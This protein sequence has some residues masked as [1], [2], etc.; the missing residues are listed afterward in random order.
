MKIHLQATIEFLTNYGWAILI[1]A[2]V[3]IALVG[4]KVF[5]SSAFTSNTCLSSGNFYCNEA[6]INTSGTLFTAFTSELRDPVNVTAVACTNNP[7]SA[8]FVNLS[9]TI[10]LQPSSEAYLF[11]NCYYNGALFSGSVGSDFNGYIIIKYIDEYTGLPG[12]T[13]FIVNLHATKFSK[14]SIT[15][16]S[17]TT[18]T[19]V[20]FRL[21]GNN[22]TTTSNTITSNTITNRSSNVTG[23]SN[24]TN[25]FLF[26]LPNGTILGGYQKFNSNGTYYYIPGQ[27][28]APLHSL[29]SGGSGYVSGLF[30]GLNPIQTQGFTYLFPDK[31]CSFGNLNG[32]CNVSVM[33]PFTNGSTINFRIEQ[34]LANIITQTTLYNPVS[35]C[36]SPVYG[37][38]LGNTTIPLSVVILSPQGNQYIS[39]EYNSYSEFYL[40]TAP[41]LC[42][43]DVSEVANNPSI[44]RFYVN[45][46]GTGY[47]AQSNLFP[48]LPY[49]LSIHQ[50]DKGL[51]ILV[52]G[53][54]LVFN[55]IG[56]PFIP[57]N[58]HHGVMIINLPQGSS[59]NTYLYTSISVFAPNNY[60]YTSI[61]GFGINNN[62]APIYFNGTIREVNANNTIRLVDTGI[63]DWDEGFYYEFQ[64]N[65]TLNST[66]NRTVTASLVFF[67][68]NNPEPNIGVYGYY[69]LGYYLV[70]NYN[71]NITYYDSIYN[72]PLEIQP[73]A[74]NYEFD[75][76]A[77]GSYVVYGGFYVRP[78]LQNG[79]EYNLSLITSAGNY[80]ISLKAVN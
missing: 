7:S 42:I 8:S 71:P 75:F 34:D 13:Q 32:L 35:G 27:Y 23:L 43:G 78:R 54:P 67:P 56:S 53:K 60:S 5:N 9:N 51:E 73:G 17:S 31:Y 33:V 14:F 64:V 6:L 46:N 21:P 18:T 3:L 26:G 41:F 62:S 68:N 25:P 74:H 65:V 24:N 20:P 48:N 16:P 12:E 80:T 70:Q 37:V 72:V 10:L 22:S 28:N 50:T 40:T 29:V 39:I 19:S 55:N 57:F 69:P 63:Q 1:I 36:P 4:L 79:S 66:Y 15:I 30:T 38:D 59:Y 61:T 2:I 76:G 58:I 77:T 49:V 45:V 47:S 44:G 11:T 52:N